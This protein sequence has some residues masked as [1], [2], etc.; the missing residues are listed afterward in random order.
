M[1]RGTVID[2]RAAGMVKTRLQKDAETQSVRAL[3]QLR[4]ITT[5]DELWQLPSHAYL[6]A[7]SRVWTR[8]DYMLAQGMSSAR[9]GQLFSDR[10]K[11]L[12]LP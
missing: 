7:N 1:E 10:A 2:T 9:G 11:V 4:E 8:S 3:G 12:I 6:V 5:M